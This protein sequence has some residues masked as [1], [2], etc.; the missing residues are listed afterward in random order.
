M[1]LGARSAFH[2]TTCAKPLQN[3]ILAVTDKYDLVVAEGYVSRM[4]QRKRDNSYPNNAENRIPSLS[5]KIIPSPYYR[6]SYCNKLI[7]EITRQAVEQRV[8]I[9]LKKYEGIIVIELDD[10]SWRL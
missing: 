1:R 3:I 7:Q 9:C 5:C 2:L 8:K 6:E 10:D 4:E